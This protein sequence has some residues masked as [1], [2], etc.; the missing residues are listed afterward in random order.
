VGG[1]ALAISRVYGWFVEVVLEGHY[2]ERAR[3]MRALVGERSVA[4]VAE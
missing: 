4:G 1:R 2:D 3:E